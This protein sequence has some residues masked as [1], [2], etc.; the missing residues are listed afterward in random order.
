MIYLSKSRLLLHRQCP[1]AL[2]LH[3]FNGE[4]AQTDPST[5]FR[6][7]IGNRL[8]E[9]ARDLHPG[10]TLVDGTDAPRALNAT[11][12]AL[13][14][15]KK[16][17]VYEAAFAH[18][19]VL[20]RADLLLPIRGGYKMVEVKSSTRLKPYHLEDAAIQAWVI[21]N[22]GMDLRKVEVAH[23]NRDFTFNGGGGMPAS[24][25]VRSPFAGLLTHVDVTRE[26][27]ELGAQ[28]PRWVRSARKTLIAGEPDVAPGA[29]CNDP[30]PCSFRAYCSPV[31]E[32]Y[33]VEIL[34]DPSLAAELRS[35]GY[36]DL[37]KVPKSHLH[38]PKH[39]RLWRGTR[40]R[41]A[42]LDPAVAP[43]L[44]AL[45]YPRYYLDFETIQLTVPLWPDTSPTTQ[46]PFQ[47]SCHVEGRTGKLRHAA[48]LADGRDD[49]RREIA[50]GLIQCVRSRGPIFVYSQ[51]FEAARLRELADTFPDLAP[52]LQAIIRRLVD[53]L[54]L[55][56][57]YYY[58][59]D[60]RGSWSL[61]DVLPTIAPKLGYANLEISNGAHAAS[62]FYRLLVAVRP[63][64]GRRVLRRNR[65]LTGLL[66][67]SLLEYC[68]RDT[69]ALVKVAHRFQRAK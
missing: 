39:L 19:A 16:H 29:Q 58:H 37:R 60:M 21:R 33:E 14:G 15:K 64:T 26:T 9:V 10:G 36:T 41:K 3:T 20:V 30:F 42:T 67:A 32:G 1:K 48:F 35:A 59:R 13:S 56:R 38:K 51:G 27:E 4:L 5:D 54:P 40:S 17:V 46:I 43:I 52:A 65:G 66:R 23:V 6:M 7:Q 62:T 63:P 61:K 44:A 28:V 34:R 24:G 53:L 22:Q 57:E 49:P 8:G 50:L 47:W 12:T 55:A 69:L 45:P 25:D 68:K 2:W 18:K 31:T 11:R